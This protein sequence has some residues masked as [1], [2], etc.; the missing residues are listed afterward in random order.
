MRSES[1]LSFRLPVLSL[2]LFSRQALGHY[3]TLPDDIR[4][5]RE[6]TTASIDGPSFDTVLRPGHILLVY[7]TKRIGTRCGGECKVYQGPGNQCM[8]FSPPA[9]CMAVTRPVEICSQSGCGDCH[10]DD[11]CPTELDWGF[12]ATP[13]N[14]GI[15]LSDIRTLTSS[16]PFKIFH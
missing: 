7:C 11:Y 9:A 13:Q 6:E 3:A 15:R 14:R 1:S 2:F 5:W 12:C 8:E 4:G 16:D 10:E